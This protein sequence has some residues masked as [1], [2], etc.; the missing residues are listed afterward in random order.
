MMTTARDNTRMELLTSGLADW[1][2]LGEIH[3]QVQQDNPGFTVEQVQRETLDTI[4]SLV[5]D[6]LVEVGDLSGPN[7]QFASW[8]T[9]LDDSIERIAAVYIN[10][11]DNETAWLWVF[12]LDL[13][14]DG[15]RVAQAIR[16]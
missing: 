16:P 7:G 3:Y 12:W 8:N 1:V 4:R 11:F 2:H 14:D 15:R 9:S 5:S 10:E 6:G 13:T